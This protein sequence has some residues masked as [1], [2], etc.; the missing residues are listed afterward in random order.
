MLEGEQ[1]HCGKP[2]AL[3]TR[4]MLMA[5][6]SAL[7]TRGEAVGVCVCVLACV[8]VCVRVNT[9]HGVC[10][11]FKCVFITICDEIARYSLSFNLVWKVPSAHPAGSLFPL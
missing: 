4:Q 10:V 3:N 11:Y 1:V 5:V 8:C 2:A 9:L 7:I 6:K